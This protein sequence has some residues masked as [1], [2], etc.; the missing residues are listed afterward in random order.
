MYYAVKKGRINTIYTDWESCKKQV[1][2]FKGAQ[3]KK[4]KTKQEATDYMNDIIPEIIGKYVYCDGSCIHNGLPNAKAG[5]GIY[6]GDNDPRNVSECISGNTNNIA[7][8]TAMMRV[9]DIV[10]G[11]PHCIVS[12]SKY[13]L[14]CVGSYGKKCESSG[15]PNIPNKELVKKL[16]YT[17][18]DTSF[19]F[20]HVYA[21]TNKK[22]IHSIGNQH[23][24]Q[25]AQDS[26]IE[27]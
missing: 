24:D 23:A 13:A 14:L 1:E 4:F 22:D 27:V 18:K 3:F 19:Q 6:F 2:G 17:Y 20:L 12:D 8:L 9:Y 16:Y 21:H 25:F 10:N 5:I 26:I 7:E 15:W 11:E